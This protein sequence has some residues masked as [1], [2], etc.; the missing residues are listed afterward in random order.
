LLITSG[1]GLFYYLR[2]VVV[3]FGPPIE[4]T[5]AA[6]S[7]PVIGYSGGLV[8]VAMT[9]LLIWLGTGPGPMIALIQ[10]IAW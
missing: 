10:K 7:Q 4:E 2:L 1:I 6:L 5:G 9:I 8:L 3:L